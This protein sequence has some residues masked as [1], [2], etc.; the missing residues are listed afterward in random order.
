MPLFSCPVYR[1]SVRYKGTRCN[2]VRLVYLVR[3]RHSAPRFRD[4]LSHGG[5]GRD[6]LT[7]PLEWIYAATDRQNELTKTARMVSSHIMSAPCVS[8][9]VSFPRLVHSSRFSFRFSCRS[10]C[11]SSLSRLVGRVVPSFLFLVPRCVCASRCA[12]RSSVPFL[13]AAV[14]VVSST[15]SPS[16]LVLFPVLF[17]LAVVYSSR[18]MPMPLSLAG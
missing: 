17:L 15:R 7:P 14:R 2:C 4:I 12:C 8:F 16:C 9:L 6:L 13:R 18:A 5:E 3:W 11:R 1:T 10:S